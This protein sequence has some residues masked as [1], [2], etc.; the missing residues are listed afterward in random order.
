MSKVSRNPRAEPDPAAS[1]RAARATMKSFFGW[2]QNGTFGGGP[3]D[4]VGGGPADAPP[5]AAPPV[6]G[7]PPG[8]PPEGEARV[9]PGAGE[10]GVGRSGSLVVKE[11]LTAGKAA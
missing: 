3:P 5:G 6:E 11:P 1:R 10:A 7:G 4:G 2:R 8:L 9:R